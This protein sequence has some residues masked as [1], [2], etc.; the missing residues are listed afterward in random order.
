MEVLRGIDQTGLSSQEEIVQQALKQ[1]DIY[2]KRREEEGFELGEA[3]DP[4]SVLRSLPAPKLALKIVDI[5]KQSVDVTIPMYVFKGAWVVG[6][7]H[8]PIYGLE[9]RRLGAA[10]PP[11]IKSKLTVSQWIALRDAK[12]PKVQIRRKSRSRALCIREAAQ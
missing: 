7:E 11:E 4:K 8:S 6:Q 10:M 3:E 12:A 2:L 9:I 5:D 1:A